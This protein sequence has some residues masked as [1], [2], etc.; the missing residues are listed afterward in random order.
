[1]EPMILTA[2][3]NG[4]KRL[5]SFLAEAVDGVSRAA[6]ARL[7]EGGGVLVDGKIAAKSCRLSGTE[8]V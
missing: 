3:N 4:G 2:E 7:I 1:M 5:D 6:A 8:T